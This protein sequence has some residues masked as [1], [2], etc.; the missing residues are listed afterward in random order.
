MKR[1]GK[2]GE[3]KEEEDKEEENE[4]RIKAELRRTMRA[5]R[6]RGK[7]EDISRFVALSY[8][9]TFQNKPLWLFLHSYT[10]HLQI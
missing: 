2:K 7:K 1:E 3:Q 6:R 4:E 5:N 8:S 9:K 10:L